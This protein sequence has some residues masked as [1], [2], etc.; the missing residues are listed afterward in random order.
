MFP[1]FVGEISHNTSFQLACSQG[2]AKVCVED[3][4]GFTYCWRGGWS[5]SIQI[6]HGELVEV[7]A[8]KWSVEFWG[9]PFGIT[10]MREKYDSHFN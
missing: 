6:Y 2:F 9:P 10:K 1:R 4:L 5:F 8:S 3:G 7:G